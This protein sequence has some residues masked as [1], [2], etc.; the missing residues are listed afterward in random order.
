MW[1]RKWIAVALILACA[2]CASAARLVWDANAPAEN[3]TGYTVY[4]DTVSGP[5]YGYQVPLGNVTEW[6]IPAEWPRTQDYYFRVTAS[7]SFGES[8]YS[9]E[10]IYYRDAPGAPSAAT[11]VRVT[12]S[13][14]R[15][16]AIALNL[17]YASKSS[18][19]YSTNTTIG[20]PTGVV[21]GDFLLAVITQGAVVEAI[22]PPSGWTLIAE[23]SHSETGRGSAH[24]YYKRASS[25][26]TSWTWT[27]AF[28]ITHGVVWRLTGVVASGAPEDVAESTAETD[29]SL[30]A[31]TNAS[32][33]TATADA[34]VIQIAWS[35]GI[36]AKFS[37]SALTNRIDETESSP[38]TC[39][40][41]VDAD[42][43]ASAGATGD[44][45][46]SAADYNRSIGILIALKPASAATSAVPIIMREYR[47]R[48]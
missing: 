16:M 19:D 10:A 31:L 34:A 11:D 25:E 20:K 14:V 3:V 35:P 48:K 45:S 18:Y 29:Y 6:P 47:A 27:H 43:Q 40:F 4:Y 30:T 42:L 33:T 17:A 24:V 12:F 1:P 7:N 36:S 28:S 39:D 41:H 2:A 9:N 22:T 13:E 26:G 15:P 46:K 5:P 44:K 8:G 38:Y 21:D 32:I 37:S 23:R